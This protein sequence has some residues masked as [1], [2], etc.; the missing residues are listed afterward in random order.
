MKNDFNEYRFEGLHFR[1]CSNKY[2]T[3]KRVSDNKNKI[4]VKVA[5]NNI[6]KTAYGYALIIDD[7]HVVFLKNWQVSQNWFGTEVLLD[8]N[9]WNI[10]EWGNFP[11]FIGNEES[12]DFDKWLKTAEEQDALVDEN[13]YPINQVKWEKIEQI[14]WYK[15]A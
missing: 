2:F 15:L 6:I 5:D 4:V 8:R 9:Y 7:K 10:K 3:M 1:S 14:N 12:Y 13:D 11:E